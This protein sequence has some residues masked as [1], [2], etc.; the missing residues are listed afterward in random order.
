M[1]NDGTRFALES[2]FE[3]LRSLRANLD[4]NDVRD[5]RHQGE[6]RPYIDCFSRIGLV[7]VG[8]AG[9]A[10]VEYPG[11]GWV[12]VR[13]AALP[14]RGRGAVGAR[15]VESRWTMSKITGSAGIAGML[16]AGA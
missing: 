14:M 1:V 6:R 9:S 16:A 7:A 13:S 10:R 2:F 5:R 4:A 11:R 15:F 8:G 3:V 12:V